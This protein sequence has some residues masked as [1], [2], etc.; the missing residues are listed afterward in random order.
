[1]EEGENHEPPRF[2]IRVNVPRGGQKLVVR[3]QNHRATL[4]SVVE[5][6]VDLH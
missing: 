4:Q 5:A 2:C 6:S 1:M 3:Q